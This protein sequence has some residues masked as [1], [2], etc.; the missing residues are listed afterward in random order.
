MDAIQAA[1]DRYVSIA[2]K[3][4]TGSDSR[5][6]QIEILQ[7]CSAAREHLERCL[8]AAEAELAH[9]RETLRLE[10]LDVPPAIP[11]ES[12]GGLSLLEAES[13][14]TEAEPT[15]LPLPV[16]DHHGIPDMLL[17]FRMDSTF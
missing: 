11:T 12:D 15:D 10:L 1:W 7:R 2:A 6:I 13:K 9:V 17:D 16:P 5:S 4:V 8:V 14:G 3:L